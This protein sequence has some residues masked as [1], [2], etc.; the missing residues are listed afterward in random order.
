MTIALAALTTLAV[1]LAFIWPFRK[2][3][4]F[5]GIL[6]DPGPRKIHTVPVPYFGGLAML[7]GVSATILWLRP[8]SWF[9]VAMLACVAA[10]GLADDVR[11]LPVWVKLVCETTIAC[12]AVGLGFSWQLTD[13]SGLNAAF[14]VIWIVGLTNS[15][16]LLDNMDG[17][18]STVAGLALVGIALLVHAPAMIA[19]PLGSAALGFLVINRPPAGMYMGD[20][21]S[22]MLGFGLALCAITAANT[23][24]G[25]H[26]VIIL[27]LPVAVAV[28]DTSLVITS[29]LATGHPVQLGGRDH[30]SHRLKLLG[31]SSYQVI[32]ATALASGAAWG[33]AALALQYPSSE[34]W[35]ALPVIAA[36]AIVWIGLLKIN[37]Y[38]SAVN[39]TLEVHGA[40]NV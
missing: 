8:Q 16:N 7:V 24:H 23:A 21:G 15:L 36:F 29:R 34:A 27:I 33:A 30:F 28:F 37:P 14:S 1:T 40:R 10:V 31:W 18:A 25:L 13:S 5:L 19:I 39:H 11:H 26:S 12:A 32:G 35:L 22:L 2:L 4:L 9:V 6:D 3:A 17:L 20:T 38:E